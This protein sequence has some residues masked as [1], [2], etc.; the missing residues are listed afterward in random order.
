[1]IEFIADQLALIKHYRRR[2]QMSLGT[3]AL[4][5]IAILVKDI[6]IS[7]ER[8]SVLL[9]ID[10]PEIWNFPPAHVVPSFTNGTLGDYSDCKLA[11]FQLENVKLELVEPG[12]NSGP[13]KETLDKYG[14]GLQ[15]LSFIVPDRKQANKTLKVIGAP[16]PNHIGYW[17]DSTYSFTDS[18]ELLGADINIKTWDDNTEKI[19]LLKANPEAHKLDLI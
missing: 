17:P 6:S 15:H 1:V 19:K 16:A 7:V 10:Q 14:E 11:V 9:G 13:W 3:V 5:H 4:C 8:W 2:L 12:P 18:R